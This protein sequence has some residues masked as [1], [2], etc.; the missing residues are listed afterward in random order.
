ML[1]CSVRHYC[2]VT[3]ICLLLHHGIRA[4]LRGSPG[5]VITGCQSINYLLDFKA[6]WW[7]SL[8]NNSIYIIGCNCRLG[9]FNKCSDLRPSDTLLG[10]WTSW[11][12]HAC[13]GK[14]FFDELYDLSFQSV[15][16]VALTDMLGLDERNI[17]W[18]CNTVSQTSL[19][20]SA[21]R[22]YLQSLTISHRHKVFLLSNV[23]G[24]RK[25][26]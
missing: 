14:Q 5:T 8:S 22:A 6:I 11:C 19:R 25:C 24:L 7:I 16:F 21:D 9:T 1:H 20:K 4:D 13:T 2:D 18:L 17:L 12:H 3:M 15:T 23:F 10:W 26:H